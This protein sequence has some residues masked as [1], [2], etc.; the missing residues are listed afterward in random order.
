MK[1]KLSIIQRIKACFILLISGSYP[2]NSE[3]LDSKDFYE[4]MQ[5]YRHSPMTEQH[6]V[7]KAF[8]E[9]KQWI[10]DNYH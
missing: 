3:I 5:S 9:V 1:K 7:I 8:N 10:K 4:V 2:I 6:N